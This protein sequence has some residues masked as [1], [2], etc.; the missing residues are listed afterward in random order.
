M[1]V[2]QN[3]VDLSCLSENRLRQGDSPILVP[4][5]RGDGARRKIG[6]VPSRSRAYSKSGRPLVSGKNSSRNNPNTNNSP[7]RLT[8]SGKLTPGQ[9]LISPESQ[10]TG[11]ANNRP[12]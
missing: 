6:T 5:H 12:P 7:S 8:A 10:R 3:K 11:A 4:D 2:P 1:R 9:D